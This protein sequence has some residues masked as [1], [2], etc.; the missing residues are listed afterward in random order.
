MSY[1][2][3]GLFSYFLEGHERIFIMFMNLCSASKIEFLCISQE[4]FDFIKHKIVSVCIFCY[5]R[6]G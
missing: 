3:G 2:L 5:C 6:P 1:T 4:V